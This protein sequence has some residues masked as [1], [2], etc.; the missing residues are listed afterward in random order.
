MIVARGDAF[1]LPL[2]DASFD[3]VIATEFIQQFGPDTMPVLIKEIARVTRTGGHVMLVWRNGFSLIRRVITPGLR[4]ADYL[5]GRPELNL[6]NHRL[7]AVERWAADQGL[8]V[9]DTR[10]LSTVLQHSSAN[11]KSIGSRLFG[12]SYIARFQKQ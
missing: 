11:I 10:W 7:K 9:L 1:A 8:K 3:V 4:L 12:T 5:R 2:R 6:F